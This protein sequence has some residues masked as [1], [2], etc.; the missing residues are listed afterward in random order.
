MTK[1]KIVGWLIFAALMGFVVM[2]AI[3]GFSFSIVGSKFY[4][5][6]NH[7]AAIKVLNAAVALNPR[8]ARGYVDLGT[9]YFALKDYEKAEKSFLKAR[10]INDD[11]CASCG[12]GMTYHALQRDND[13]EREFTRAIGLNPSDVCAY[14]QSARMY[15]DQHKYQKAIGPLKQVAALKPNSANAHLYLGNAYVF[16]GEYEAGIEPYKESIRLDPR[17]VRG[18]LQLGIAYNYLRRYEEAVAEYKAGLKVSPND[19]D[20]HYALA[21]AYLALRNRTAAFAEYETLRKLNPDMAA[22]LFADSSAPR[23]RKNGQEKLYFIP[24]GN[25]SSGSLNKLVT[26]YQHKP[27]VNPICKRPLALSLPTIDK[28]R[29]QVIAEEVIELLKRSYPELAADPNAI[30][31]AL[32]EEDMYIREKNWQGAFSYWTGGR[33]AVVSSAHMNPVNL[34]E[35]ANSDLLEARMRKM[36]LK[37]IGMLYYL[38]PTNH[39]PKSVLYGNVGGVEDLDNMS[40]DF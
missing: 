31:I 10:S 23:E 11:S 20:T 5:D 17:N 4:A 34:G 6:G 39:D 26:Y 24:V 32:T 35:A 25:F 8:F 38:M 2:P 14:N 33:F 30:L 27:G 12:L 40:E 3:V 13:A 29:R 21:L 1:R 28:R 36:V 16:A 22:E 19:E 9:N 37:N 15:Y 7:H 18:H